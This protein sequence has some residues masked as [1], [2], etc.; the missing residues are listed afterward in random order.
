VGW[1]FQEPTAG[2]SGLQAFVLVESDSG[3][4]LIPRPNPTE[5]ARLEKNGWSFPQD[6]TNE[7][8]TY[9]S[10]SKVCDA[11]EFLRQGFT[12]ASVEWFKQGIAD[13]AQIL[14]AAQ[15]QLGK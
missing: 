1:G 7:E 12:G 4:T 8:G 14:K 5:M 3:G 13:A 6:I 10:F 9:S 2:R 11:A 15:K